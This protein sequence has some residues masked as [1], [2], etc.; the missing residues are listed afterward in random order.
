MSNARGQEEESPEIDLP[1][2]M[3]KISDS[4]LSSLS[5][6]QVGF[7]VSLRAISS[8]LSGD[9]LK[10]QIS[11]MFPPAQLFSKEIADMPMVWIELR[12]FLDA[13][14][15]GLQ[16]HS[17]RRVILT[18]AHGLYTDAEDQSVAIEIA[19][20][21]IASGRRVRQD[22][23]VGDSSSTANNS[24]APTTS[25]GARET[26]AQE[27]MAHNVAMRLKDTDKKFSGDLGECWH[28]FV[29]DYQQ[30]SRDYNL[31]ATQKFQY[32]HN[33]LRRDALRFYLDRVQNYATNFP[34]AVEMIDREYNSPVRQ[35]RVKNYLNGLRVSEFVTEGTEI[36]SALAKVY[37]L[38]LKLSRQ[39]PASHRGDAHKME[40][41]RGAVIGYSWSHEPLSRVATHGLSFQQLY[42]EL[43][44][45][46]Q[47]E[48]EAEIMKQRDRATQ[49]IRE[50]HDEVVGV[51]YAGQG[52]YI[53]KQNF[54]KSYKSRK[55]PLEISGCFNCDDPSHMIKDCPEPKNAAKAAAR[56]LEYLQKK[57]QNNAIHHVLAEL[58]QQLDSQNSSDT[59][60]NDREIF[61]GLV[62]VSGNYAENEEIGESDDTDDN[63]EFEVFS[64]SKYLPTSQCEKFQ[65][66]CIDSGAEITVIGKKQA[67]L[68]C[69][70]VNARLQADASGT[71]YKFGESRHQ[72]LGYI[73]IRIPVSETHFANVNAAV[74]EIDVPFLL[75]LDALTKFKVILN[76]GDDTA[77]SKCDGWKLKMVRKLGHVYIEWPPSIL[78]TETELRRIHRHF[79]HPRVDKLFAVMKRADPKLVATDVYK[80]LEKIQSTC[81]VCQR[82]SNA[83]HRFRVSLPNVNCV[84]NRVVSLDLMKLGKRTVLH[85]VDRDT[86]F[87]AACFLV[88]ETTTAVWEAFLRTWVAP[89]VG[90]PECL[91]F[92]QGPQFGKS[93]DWHGLLLSAGIKEQ[94]SGVESHN[95][96][97]NGERY[98]AFLRRVFNKVRADSPELS[99]EL[100]LA[101]SLKAV[102]DTA[103]PNGLVPTLLV[104]GVIP[105]I[106]LRASQLPNQ[107]VRMNAMADARKEMEQIVARSRIAAA[108]NWN[109]PKCSDQQFN[110]SD[111]VLMFREK[112]VGKWVG[113]YTIKSINNK[114]VVLDTGDRNIL[115]SVDKIRVYKSNTN[116]PVILEKTNQKEGITSSFS[117]KDVF[118]REREELDKLLNKVWEIPNDSTS[119]ND[120]T[121]FVVKVIGPDDPRGK[122]DDFEKA[123]KVEVEGLTKRKIWKVVHKDNVPSEAVVL[124]G[125]FFMTLKN[126][127][128]PNEMAKVRYI[129]QGYNDPDKPFIVHDTST[130][131][132][133]SI[134]WILSAASIH[135]FRIFSHDVT[136][137]Y[138]QSK[139]KLTRKIFIKPKKK[140]LDT[141]Q[142]SPDYLLELIRPLYGVCDAGDYWG[143]T[144]ESHVVND[145]GMKPL[146][147]DPS[148]YVKTGDDGPEGITGS[149]VDDCLHAGNEEFQKTTE[150]SL[151]KFDSKP[152]VYDNFDFF[153]TQIKTEQGNFFVGQEYYT[154]NMSSVPSN[155]TF[156]D[157]RRHRALFSWINNTRPD[158]VCYSNRAAQVTEKTFG[159][160][161]INELNRGIKE[162]KSRE[163]K[164]LR[165][166]PLEL[167]S[168]HLRIYADASFSSNDDLSSQLG[169]IILL[170]DEAN[171]CHVLDFSSKKSKRIVRSIMGGEVC[172]FVDAFDYA[173]MMMKDLNT[174]LGKVI[175]IFMFT[176]SKQ[177]FDALTKGKRTTEKRLMIDILSA[178]QSYKRFEISAIGLVTGLSNPADGLSKIGG[179]GAL[180]KILETGMDE[181]PVEQWIERTLMQATNSV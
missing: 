89:Y 152:R 53:R 69:G 37:K 72:G 58:C 178:R 90:Y 118:M 97:G 61:E 14:G 16:Q 31:S 81:D 129:A 115:S 157:F 123:K 2:F 63:E 168:V 59:D 25:S 34:Q 131:R 113:P 146:I 17:S 121:F 130:L 181:T 153:G 179:N 176:D 154:R 33:I 29:D 137:A 171:N 62:N 12:N 54:R 70:W 28:E 48:K 163:L 79:Y 156:A 78:Y 135:K 166:P 60:E 116:D 150:V 22:L 98:H 173:F 52:R 67:E 19:N 24:A 1:M 104:F 47:L 99:E 84:F 23:Q 20:L 30:I 56:R 103:G 27:K 93:G 15:V 80:D 42:G 3:Q 41:L 82:E 128:T 124:G 51:N 21:I 160:D 57:K 136:Q 96:L 85:I 74:V 39:V 138:L 158:L 142:I 4:A 7:V 149:Y 169:W 112:P 73:S 91:A 87:G 86:K 5:P 159:K 8:D 143:E 83:P 134:R 50:K 133:S 88:H 177:L 46:L 127:G 49:A 75:G 40:F 94:P 140:D 13:R 170:C 165:Y 43:E 55:N 110:V 151:K 68:Y 167:E 26:I 174:M 148:L 155:A 102:N 111:E 10:Q 109:V 106:P 44:A 92:D 64:V 65:G 122:K 126:F 162:A 114:S 18:L 175:P 107:I 100:S 105:R 141:F 36:S 11:E 76:F 117:G 6:T 38:I 180:Q 125:R 35:T 145:I 77:Q 101:L 66:A 144:I 32:L 9:V 164:S 161:K 147:S 132:A 139:D 108:L 172:A 95:A 120:P 119:K 71:I 45:A